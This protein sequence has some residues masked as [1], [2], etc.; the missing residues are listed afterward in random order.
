MIEEYHFQRS[1]QYSSHD[2]ED[3]V[4]S[5]DSLESN[6]IRRR[7]MSEDRSVLTQYNSLHHRTPHLSSNGENS[8]S[9]SMSPL[10]SNGKRTRT[11]LTKKRLVW[12]CSLRTYLSFLCI[13]YAFLV[14]FAVGW[15][16]RHPQYYFQKVSLHTSFLEP[17]SNLFLVRE[18]LEQKRMDERLESFKR[19]DAVAK[20]RKHRTTP[21][22]LISAV[23]QFE[24][25]TTAKSRETSRILSMAKSKDLCGEHAKQASQEH[26]ESFPANNV[27]NSKARV[28]ITGILNPIGF[29][30]AL[31]LKELCGVEVIGGIDP[32]FPNTVSHRLELQSRIELLS[33]NIPKFFHPI[34]QP[35]VGL[36]PKSTKKSSS[37]ELSTTGEGN[38]LEMQPTHIVHLASYS[39]LEYQDFNDE[40]KRNIQSPYVNPGRSNDM[41]GIRSS[42][43]GMEQI[44]LSIKENMPEKQPQFLYASTSQTNNAVQKWSKAIDEKLAE[45]YGSLHGLQSIA[46]RFPDTV[47]GPWGRNGSPITELSNIA[48]RHLRYNNGTILSLQNSESRDFVFVDDIVNAIIAAMQYQDPSHT[49]NVFDLSSDFRNTL[50][51]ASVLMSK[52]A[53]LKGNKNLQDISFQESTEVMPTS[54]VKRTRKRLNWAPTT[55]ILLGIAKTF[56]WHLDH[57]SSHGNIKTGD[58]SLITGDQLRLRLG[59]DTCSPED[60]RCHM[61]FKYLPCLSECSTKHKCIPSIFEDTISLV[62]ELT[63]DCDIILY[64]QTLGHNIKDLNLKAIYKEDITPIVC[65]LAFVPEESELV[66]AVVKKVPE[67]KLRQFGIKI[68]P[69]ESAEANAK[70][71]VT[72]L[73]GRLLY[74]GWILIWVKDANAPL[75]THDLSLLKLSPGKFFSSHAKHAVYIDPSFPVSPS[76]D[77]VLFLVAQTHRPALPDRKAYYRNEKGKKIKYRL[78]PEPERRAVIIMSPLKYK[79]KSVNMELP[80]ISVYEATKYMQAEIGETPAVKEPINIKRQREFYERVGAYLNKLDFRSIHEAWYK[81]EL[82]NWVRTKWIVHDLKHEEAR[83]LRCNW[84][85]EHVQWGNN[86]DQL[87]F[88]YVLATHDLKRRVAFQEPDDHIKPQWYDRPELLYLADTHEWHGLES[89]GNR[90]ALEA[91]PSKQLEVIADHLDL[92]DVDSETE[93]ENIIEP[94]ARTVHANHVP[95][96]VRIISERV[97]LKARTEW[98]P[99]QQKDI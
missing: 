42:Q 90:D 75:Q 92:D 87:S 69:K 37:N 31:A 15:M 64:M 20:S 22:R 28:L 29:H 83:K 13:G 94:I 18:Q 30:L 99:N 8:K 49:S 88:A 56:A 5:E 33:S 76:R 6:D 66:N 80:K 14:Y 46:I 39:L 98:S 74:K 86:L 7:I 78:P 54:L 59:M 44:L 45:T 65:N 57:A 36:D 16:R 9:K 2:S 47:Y 38:I 50:R 19:I 3:D 70:R 72:G 71:K 25:Q 68:N 60:V 89:Q 32:L 67:S 63:E 11:I 23:E 35:F 55:S 51:T 93:S 34:V 21:P 4:D 43:I 1:Y 62:Q 52:L 96:F 91:I 73:N 61:G 77:D 81:Y 24:L 41:F 85:Q 17:V 79:S 58:V 84:Y 82:K 26:P 53:H 48:I 27:L 40:S 10:R 12:I 97:M 95:L